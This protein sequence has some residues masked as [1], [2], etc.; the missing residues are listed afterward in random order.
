[1]QGI[2]CFHSFLGTVVLTSF[3]AVIPPVWANRNKKKTFTRGIIAWVK[4]LSAEICPGP[5]PFDRID[6]NRVGLSVA[7]DYSPLR[8]AKYHCSVHGGQSFFRISLDRNYLRPLFQPIRIIRPP[9][10]PPP[11]FRQVRSPVE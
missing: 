7:D 4:V 10:H 5:G 3:N 9:M 2:S 11:P 6:G 8:S 1:M